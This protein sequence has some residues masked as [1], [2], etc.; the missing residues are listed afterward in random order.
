VR[1]T[2]LSRYANRDESLGFTEV[3]LFAV[4]EPGVVALLAPAGVLLLRR[5]R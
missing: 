1:L 3:Q 5:R 2:V 4:P